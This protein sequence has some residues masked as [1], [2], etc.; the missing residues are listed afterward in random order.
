MTILEM[1]E[2]FAAEFKKTQLWVDMKIIYENSQWHREA[3]VAVH[4]NMVIDW[5]I[6]NL[7]DDRL[8]LQ[9]MLTL[10]ACLFHDVGKPAN[11]REHGNFHGH[12]QASAEIW[13]LYAIDNPQLMHTVALTD[14]DIETIALM[15]E[16]HVPFAIRRFQKRTNLKTLMWSRN[17]MLGHT[18]HGSTCYLQ[19]N[20][21]GY[22]TYTKKI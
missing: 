1:F 16:H 8:D 19:I 7:H 12:E 22:L 18:K 4:T 5:Y 10:M 9:R 21:G 15:I 6:A 3:S 17:G 11:F 14:Y 20:T 2:A 13:R